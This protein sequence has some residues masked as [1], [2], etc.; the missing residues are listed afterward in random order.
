MS[1]VMDVLRTLPGAVT[2]DRTD[3]D[4]VA[5]D[6]ARG[7]R[8]LTR[9]R[10]QRFAW[11][12]VAVAAVAVAV[13]GVGQF[14]GATPTTTAAHGPA[15]T[16]T[17]AVRLRLVAYTGA[18][19]VGFKVSTVPQGWQV[20]SSDRSMF[21]VTPPGQPTAPPGPGRAVSLQGSI[22]VS[23]QSLSRLPEGAPVTRVEVN[24][25][26]GQL[27]FPWEA[28]GKLSDIRWLIFP[29]ASGRQVLVQVPAALG[30]GDDQIVRFAEGVTVTAEAQTVGG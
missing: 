4:V 19:P 10:R 27:G 5:G 7:H 13:V 8:A 6:V 22:A 12:G 18:Q 11:S 23:L 1:D 17:Q 20:V 24:G 14:G 15:P 16:G 2:P 9:R 25:R 21:V 30:L 26:A 28:K 29:D 3:P